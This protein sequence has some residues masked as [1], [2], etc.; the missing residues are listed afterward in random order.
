MCVAE[1]HIS[2]HI[3]NFFYS[4]FFFIVIIHVFFIYQMVMTVEYL[5][6]NLLWTL[7]FVAKNIYRFKFIY[8]MMADMSHMHLMN[9]IPLRYNLQVAKRQI[10]KHMHLK[11]WLDNL[12]TWDKS[13]SFRDIQ[14]IDIVRVHHF[15]LW[16]LR[17]K[18]QES[19]EDLF[20]HIPLKR[21]RL[22]KVLSL[23]IVVIILYITP[24]ISHRSSR[25]FI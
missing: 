21:F 8:R 10:L 20:F 3:I 9:L 25:S 14:N 5:G 24:F 13:I 2:G 12:K 23:S 17:K 19:H 4:I 16:G 6:L 22:L 11:N 15:V 18:W 1:A 7:Q